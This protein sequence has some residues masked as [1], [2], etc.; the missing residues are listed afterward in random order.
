MALSI[1]TD[2]TDIPSILK[3]L[4]LGGLPSAAEDTGGQ[5]PA[6]PSAG[7]AD[8]PTT[9]PESSSAPSTH[10]SSTPP[11]KLLRLQQALGTAEPAP[12]PPSQQVLS[13]QESPLPPANLAKG[14]AASTAKIKPTFEERHPNIF[15]I[16][17]AARDFAENAGPGVGAPTFAQGFATAAAQPAQKAKEELALATGKAELEKTK[18]TTEQLKSQ[19]TLPNGLTV[20]FALAQKLY[21]TLTTEQGKNSR[22][23]AALKSKEGIALRNK[24]LRLDEEGNQEP[25]PYDELTPAEQA[26][27]DLQQSQQDAAAARAEL[28]RQKNDPNSAAYKAAMGRLRV[29]QQNAATAAGRL[30]LEQTKYK[31]DYFGTDAQG[32]ALPGATTD[33]QGRPI[34]PRLANAAKIPADRLKRGDLANN[35]ISNLDDIVGLIHSNPELFGSLSGR[36]TTVREMLGSDEPAI[37]EI[38]IA[39]HN[40][41]LASAGVHGTRSQGAVEKT[42]NELLNHWKDGD[43]AVLGGISQAKK[44]LQQF[45][46]NQQL[47]N[48]AIPSKSSAKTSTAKAAPSGASDEVYAADGKTLIGHVIGGKY[49]PLQKKTQ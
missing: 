25:I 26:K 11:T 4:G 27:I 33:E 20:P 1:K 29:A 30:G 41:A 5:P 39:A 13:A 46:D 45:V 37:R 44:S 28:D 42:E 12:P 38:A 9:Q 3:M 35:A 17:G 47:G 34:G 49:V 23:Q 43:S 32:N 40:Y 31:A 14:E 18:A 48:K 2:V 21:P 36:I 24:G 15:K 10:D 16:L 6:D 8:N 22:A 7:G 19:V